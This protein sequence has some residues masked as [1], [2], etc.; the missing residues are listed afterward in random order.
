ME[1]R[2]IEVAAGV[3]GSSR[4]KAAEDCRT[5]RRFALIQASEIPTG[6]GVR[7]SSAALASPH[8]K[9]LPDVSF[10]IEA[11]LESLYFRGMLIV[12]IARVAERQTR[13]T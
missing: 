12:P 8:A 1:S 3:D 7:Q 5:P 2:R 10:T 4:Y 13:Q 9:A 6:F 11:K